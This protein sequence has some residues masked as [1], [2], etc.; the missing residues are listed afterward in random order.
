MSINNVVWNRKS[1]TA[2]YAHLWMNIAHKIKFQYSAL[3]TEH[4]KH[5]LM[6]H[7]NGA[8]N[9][10]KKLLANHKKHTRNKHYKLTMAAVIAYKHTLTTFILPHTKTPTH[11]SLVL[12]KYMDL[13]VL[14]SL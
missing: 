3:C 5:S 10:I 2:D 8:L 13:Y 6:S 11:R 7:E 1:E 9:F 14:Y 12:S 4:T